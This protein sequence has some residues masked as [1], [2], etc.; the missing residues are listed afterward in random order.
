MKNDKTRKNYDL[1]SEAVETLAGNGPKTPKYSQK[2]LEK[3]TKT[4]KFRIPKWLK[5]I[6][7]KAWF[8]GAVC[9]FFLWGLGLYLPHM[10]DMMFVLAVGMGA[11][12]DLLVNNVIRFIATTPGSNDDWM[13]FPQKGVAALLL[14]V[15]YAGVILFCVYTL[16]NVINSVIIS[17]TGATDTVPLGV[18]PILFGIFCM[19]VDVLLLGMKQLAK[20][21]LRDAKAAAEE[22]EQEV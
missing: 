16:Y 9:F 13:M 4:K 1:K 6:G 11:V 17:I 3:Y 12:T 20:S 21:M 2:E 22:E 18:E 8:Y 19:I 5:M 14:N 7:I 15:L 10:L